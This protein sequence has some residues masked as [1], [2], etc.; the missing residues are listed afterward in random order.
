MD[1]VCQLNGRDA[2]LVAADKV[3]GDEPL[4]EGY[5]RILKDSTDGDGEILAAVRATKR[6]ILAVMAMMLTAERADHIVLIPTGLKDGLTAFDFRIKVGCQFKDGVETSEV[7][8]K[9]QV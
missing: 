9:S 8:H 3:H 7:N 6:T 2:L 5:L 4:A 1:V